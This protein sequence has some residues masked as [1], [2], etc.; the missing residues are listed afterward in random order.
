MAERSMLEE[1][2]IY[3]A[4]TPKFIKEAL[5]GAKK[6]KMTLLA[7]I[8]VNFPDETYKVRPKEYWSY[9]CAELFSRNN[10]KTVDQIKGML[11]GYFHGY[12]SPKEEFVEF[13][14]KFPL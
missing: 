10:G 6:E 13:L 11:D 7:W 14:R 12:P 8:N 1:E 4:Q 2:R 3:R 5:D 9:L